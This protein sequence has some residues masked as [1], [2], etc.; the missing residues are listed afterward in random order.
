MTIDGIKRY[1]LLK[2]TQEQ[3]V[4]NPVGNKDFL[5]GYPKSLVKEFK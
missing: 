3:I 5:M 1:T 2:Y 4:T